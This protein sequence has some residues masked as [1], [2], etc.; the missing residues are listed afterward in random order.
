MV[1]QTEP[2]SWAEILRGRNGL[3]SLALAGGVALHAVNVY[4]VTTIL[5]SVVRDI[6]GLAYYAWNMTLF[7]AASILGSA[8]SPKT[9]DKLGL[10]RAFLLAIALFSLG[11]MG[12]GSAYSMPW[13]LAGRTV[14]GL[15]GGLLLGLSYS[16]VRLVFEERLWPRAM[17]LVSSMWGVATLAGPAIGGIFAQGGYWRLAFWMVLPFAAGLAWLVH[18]Q[19]GGQRRGPRS[20]VKA[21]LG[22]ISLMIVSVLLVSIASLSDSWLW[23]FAGLA[24]G[25]AMTAW[26][27]RLDY[28]SQARILPSGA[29]TPGSVLA[30]AYLCVC[31]LSMGV[32]IEVFIPYFLQVIHGKSPL[33][34]GYLMALLS[35]GW[36]LGSFLSSGRSRRTVDKLILLGPLLSAVS[37]AL[38]AVLMPMGSL[39]EGSGRGFAWILPLLLGVGLGVGLCWPHLLTRIFKASPAGQES[40]ASAAIITLQLYAIALGASLAG[41]VSNA[42]GLTDPGGEAGARQA[43]VA[44]FTVFACAPGLAIFLGRGA[45][46]A[47]AQQA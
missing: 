19:L 27:G 47:A 23:N 37:L 38:L 42:A 30:S 32:T 1:D 44:L 2:A 11:T 9:I 45:R 21:P 3:R 10:H 41:M 16:A 5:P 35:A 17:V 13:M 15:G 43:A 34:A 28:R 36:T 8:L 25:L 22:N 24:A 31:L 14:Q 20:G 7:V 6:G 18:A 33:A 39:S 29:Y 46:R 40:I 12:C 26:I 4:I